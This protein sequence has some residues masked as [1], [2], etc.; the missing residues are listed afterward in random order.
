MVQ[1]PPGTCPPI[2]LSSIPKPVN[3][4]NSPSESGKAPVSLFENRKSWRRS[5]KVP[6]HSGTGPE[7]KFESKNSAPVVQRETQVSDNLVAGG[8]E[9]IYICTYEAHR[10]HRVLL[11]CF[12]PIC[13]RKDKDP[14]NWKRLIFDRIRP[15]NCLNSRTRPLYTNVWDI[16]MKQMGTV[17][18]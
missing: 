4:L 12:H 13:C 11:E 15:R 3:F 18:W 16:W 8:N 10:A 2:S 6:I 17:Y 9:L 5:V 1:I 7:N 14:S